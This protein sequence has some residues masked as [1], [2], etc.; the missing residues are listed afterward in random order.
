[1]KNS[2]GNPRGNSTLAEFLKEV[3][4]FK[5]PLEQ[6][7]TNVLGKERASKILELD[8]YLLSPNSYLFKTSSLRGFTACGFSGKGNSLFYVMIS[9][10]EGDE[11]KIDPTGEMEV[12]SKALRTSPFFF[13]SPR[14]IKKHVKELKKTS[15]PPYLALWTHEYS[16]FIGYCLQKSL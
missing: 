6:T 16:H 3:Q 12:N 5:I 4:E 11:F 13:F 7:Y 9:S 1:M 8:K 14:I 10:K 15:L 2:F